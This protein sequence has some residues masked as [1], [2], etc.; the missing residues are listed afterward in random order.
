MA[1]DAHRYLWHQ[2]MLSLLI[3]PLGPVR[4]GGVR[5]KNTNGLW[6]VAHGPHSRPVCFTCIP[7]TFIGKFQ[8]S[9]KPRLGSLVKSQEVGDASWDFCQMSFIQWL[10]RRPTG[11]TQDTE[12]KV[13]TL[14][15]IHKN[16]M[17]LCHGLG[18]TLKIQQKKMNFACWFDNMTHST[19]LGGN[20]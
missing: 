17:M 6:L 3:L 8:I 10:S 20:R 13:H 12:L 5:W 14:S 18:Y 15:H 2:Y 19:H 9:H 4:M 1:S 7:I 16:L 11:K